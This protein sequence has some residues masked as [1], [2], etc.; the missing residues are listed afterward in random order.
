MQNRL[1]EPSGPLSPRLTIYRWHVGML[2]SIGHRASGLALILFVPIYLWLLRGMTGSEDNFAAVF[3]WL[4]SGLGKVSI[5]LVG[6]SLI[7]HF[8]NGI[9]FIAIDAGWG[10]SRESMRRSARVVFVFT[11]LVAVLLAVML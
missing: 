4:H 7:Y 3:N 2:A 10:E 5:W 11:V 8:C 6:I 1:K 9:R